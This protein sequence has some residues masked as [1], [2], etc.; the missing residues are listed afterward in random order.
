MPSQTNDRTRSG[1]AE[2][3][4]LL[5]DWLANFV[6]GLSQNLAPPS[7]QEGSSNG[8]GD[9]IE[10]KMGRL[11]TDPLVMS[12]ARLVFG[13]LQSPLLHPTEGVADER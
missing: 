1:F 12:M 4:A 8:V 6:Y 3:R 11:M 13:L 5:R 9:N 7:E 2:A 10:V